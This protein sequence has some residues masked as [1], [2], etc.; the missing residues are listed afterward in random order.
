MTPY[1]WLFNWLPFTNGRSP[2]GGPSPLAWA[3]GEVAMR[4]SW[5][6]TVLFLLMF[7][8]F[9]EVR[10]MVRVQPIT[11]SPAEVMQMAA[12]DTFA[13]ATVHKDHILLQRRSAQD[14]SLQARAR[15][16]VGLPIDGQLLVMRS[17]SAADM[18][19]VRAQL[20]AHGVRILGS[21]QRAR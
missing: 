4:R 11:V 3:R 8:A 5:I 20:A 9:W 18:D 16:W 6:V 19:R 14:G 21:E 17:E 12:T 7:V 15:A 1:Q 10:T 13:T 2:D